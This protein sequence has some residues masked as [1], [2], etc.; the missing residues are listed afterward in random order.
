MSSISMS[1]L[2][3]T[4]EREQLYR[5]INNLRAEEEQLEMQLKNM[6]FSS[7]TVAYISPEQSKLLTG[8]LLIVFEKL[9]VYIIENVPKTGNTKY[10][11]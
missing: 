3:S 9:L 8:L 10:L 11:K 7:M 2:V 5:E 1:S 4:S 6:S